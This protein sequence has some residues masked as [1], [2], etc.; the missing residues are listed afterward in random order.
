M[1]PYRKR[2]RAPQVTATYNKRRRFTYGR[3]RSYRPGNT[4]KRQMLRLCETKKSSEA[5]ENNQ[6]FHNVTTYLLQ[7]LKTSQGLTDPEGLQVSKQNRIGD[8]VIARGIKFKFHMFNKENRPNVT[9][10]IILFR[11]NT[12][13]SI[14]AGMND[15]YF[16]RGP[17]G[18]GGQFNRMLDNPNSDRVKVLRNIFIKS[19]NNYATSFEKSYM[20]EFY[21]P[22]KDQKLK[23]R[24]D[25]DPDTLLWDLGVAVVCYDAFGTALT[26]NIASFAYTWTFYFKDP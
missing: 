14:A 12:L 20:R 19:T 7:C 15:A 26:D 6:L 25:N 9:Y 8:E 1:P 2:T 16:W 13:L 5:V 17:N 24:D 4:V 22:M 11:Y 3:R 21:F 23:Y 18:A 10:R